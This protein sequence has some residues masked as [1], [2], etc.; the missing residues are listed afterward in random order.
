MP[1]CLSFLLLLALLSGCFAPREEFIIEPPLRP[2]PSKLIIIDPGHGGGDLGTHSLTKPYYEEKSLNLTTAYMLSD[3]LQDMGY[4]TIL[5]RRNDIFIP[6]SER[7]DFANRQRP[8]LFISVHF[9][10][11]PNKNAHGVEVYYYL[12]ENQPRSETSKKLAELVLDNII[13]STAAKPRGVKHG[14]FAVIRE[15]QMPAILVEGGFLTNQ[16][17]RKN[18]KNPDYLKKLASGMAQGID[19]FVHLGK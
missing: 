14:N 7:A 4:Q 2:A 11:A 1:R 3:I 19:Q 8:L 5:T 13:A 12:Q 18:I 17:E 16:E 6:L 10:S 15:T 9:N